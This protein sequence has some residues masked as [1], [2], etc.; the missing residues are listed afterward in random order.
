VILNGGASVR[1]ASYIGETVVGKKSERA[2][3][4][5]A[6]AFIGKP[7][8]KKEKPVKINKLLP[9]KDTLE[10]YQELIEAMIAPEISYSMKYYTL[11]EMEIETYYGER[12]MRTMRRCVQRRRTQ[13]ITKED[14]TLP[15]DDG[16][17]ASMFAHEL[18]FLKFWS[19][20]SKTVVLPP[21]ASAQ[22][23]KNILG[24]LCGRSF[25]GTDSGDR[26][27]MWAVRDGTQNDGGLPLQ[28]PLACGKYRFHRLYMT[29]YGVH[30][31]LSQEPNDQLMDSRPFM[32]YRVFSMMP[33]DD[34]GCPWFFTKDYVKDMPFELPYLPPSE[35]ANL[36]SLTYDFVMK[37]G[38]K[39][40]YYDR[41]SKQERYA[42]MYG[43]YD[44]GLDD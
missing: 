30:A 41:Y 1:S 44:T 21:N 42:Q 14:L 5:R 18:D 24:T 29:R 7:K 34:S 10:S 17:L 2:L 6:A 26:V 15:D 22:L 23:A 31:T 27:E 12:T 11:E 39:E 28:T 4:S 8:F 20:L 9:F 32:G 19:D 35:W 40:Q 37:H 38:N 16:M 13:Q 3:F 25:Q 36:K 43:R 33:D